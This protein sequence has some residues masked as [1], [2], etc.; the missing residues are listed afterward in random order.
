MTLLP[1]GKSLQYEI[2]SAREAGDVFISVHEI[3]QRL[4]DNRKFSYF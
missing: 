1:F 3:F 2:L 4:A